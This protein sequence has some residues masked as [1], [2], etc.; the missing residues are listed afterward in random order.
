LREFSRG[1]AGNDIIDLARE[2]ENEKRVPEWM[3]RHLNTSE[4]R[5]VFQSTRDDDALE[6][7]WR[8]FAAKEAGYKAFCQAELPTPRAGYKCLEVNLAES[9]VTHLPS[10]RWAAL[11]FPEAD[12]QKIHAVAI[13]GEPGAPVQD[14]WNETAMLRIGQDASDFVRENLTRG[15]AARLGQSATTFAL[16]VVSGIPRVLAAGRWLDW[17]VSLSHSGRFVAWSCVAPLGAT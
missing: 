17:S 4:E 8:I 2:R 14:V 10:G 5:V 7:F 15:L 11:Q 16:G 13:V 6:L 9:L 12:S 1:F 3:S